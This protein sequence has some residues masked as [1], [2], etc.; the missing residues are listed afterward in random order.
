VTVHHSGGDRYELTARDEVARSIRA[1]QG[2]HRDRRGWADIGYHY[3]I[4]PAG[5]VWEGRDGRRLGAHAGPGDLNEGNVGVLL[6]G[7]FE[8]QEPSAAQLATLRALLEALREVCGVAA[9][10]IRGHNEVREGAGFG[11]TECPGRHL[12]ARLAELIEGR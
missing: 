12:M 6:L 4:D 1:I 11:A 3:V 10:E 5:R 9:T 2:D 8:V 7:N